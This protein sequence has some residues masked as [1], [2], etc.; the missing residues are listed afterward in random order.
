MH[1]T[2]F[3]QRNFYTGKLWH[4]KTCPHRLHREVFTHRNFY[5]QKLYLEQLLHRNF[6]AQKPLRT[7]VFMH[8]NFYTDAFTPR[9]IYT[10]KLLHIEIWWNLCIVYSTLLHTASFYTLRGFASP[11]WS[12]S[13]R[14]VPSHDLI[15]HQKNAD[16]FPP[17]SNEWNI[18][19]HGVPIDIPNWI[20]KFQV[21]CWINYY[22]FLIHSVE[23]SKL[24]HFLSR[25][26]C[27]MWLRSHAH[28]P[29]L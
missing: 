15:H 12:P 11:S 14:G 6:S 13:F 3:T 25:I 28:K 21:I 17:H 19:K 10:Q 8:S 18:L 2:A 23:I 29:W 4:R 1:R 9:F 7:E 22:S 5:T 16:F 26:M 27:C 20:S 24:P